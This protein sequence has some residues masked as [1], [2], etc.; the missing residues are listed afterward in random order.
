MNSV[1]DPDPTCE[2]PPMQLLISGDD[3]IKPTPTRI[4]REK[5]TFCIIKSF[6]AAQKF[7]NW[8]RPLFRPWTDHACHQKPVPLMFPLLWWAGG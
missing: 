1:V 6:G 3:K 7:K 5:Y 8:P 2:V 4:N